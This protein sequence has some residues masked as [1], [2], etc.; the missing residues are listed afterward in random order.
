M[1]RGG[2]R[3][4]FESGFGGNFRGFVLSGDAGFLEAAEFDK[5]LC[6][7]A[8]EALLLNVEVFELLFVLQEDFARMRAG[9]SDSGR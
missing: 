7:A 4:N 6:A 3:H 5:F 8:G 1:G 2:E 9:R